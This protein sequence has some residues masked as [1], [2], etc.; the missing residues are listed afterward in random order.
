[1]VIAAAAA[2]EVTVG[3]EVFHAFTTNLDAI[4]DADRIPPRSPRATMSRRESRASLIGVR[5]NDALSEFENFKKKFLLANKHITKLNSTLSTK[6]EELNAQISTLYVENLR[7]RASEIALKSQLKRERAKSQ[8]IMAEADSAIANFTKHFG[9]LHE[10]YNVPRGAPS[11]PQRDPP[12]PRARR[13][14]PDPNASPPVP[15]LARAPT[16]PGIYEEDEEGSH[17][18]EPPSP[19]PARRRTKPRTSISTSSSSSRL[20]LPTRVSSPPPVDLE[21]QLARR[22]KP[23]RRQSGLLAKVSSDSSS[24]SGVERPPSPAYGSPARLEAGRAER[25]NEVVATGALVD[26]D[27]DIDEVVVLPRRKDRDR[28]SDQDRDKKATKSS[29]SGESGK[30]RKRHRDGDEG[31]DRS[32]EQSK[33]NHKFQDVTNSPRSRSR[34]RAAPGALAAA[35]KELGSDR[36]RTPDQDADALFGTRTFLT[37]PVTTPPAPDAYP[38]SESSSPPEPSSLDPNM[39]TDDNRGRRARKSV[40]YAEPKLNTKMRKPAGADPAPTVTKR[41]RMSTS[42]SAPNSRGSDTSAP[43]QP[44]QSEI[45]LADGDDTARRGEDSPAVVRRSRKMRPGE[46]DRADE[47]E[48]ESEGTQADA[49]IGFGT[50][51]DWSEAVPNS[52]SLGRRRSAQIAQARIGI[53]TMEA[54][55]ERRHSLAI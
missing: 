29:R 14:V 36:Q 44:G 3:A 40:N 32:S 8:K 50:R 52:T 13:P 2:G 41:K 31:Y 38:T 27:E 20:P 16:I 39:E 37:T 9:F 17:S 42:S 18:E 12:P 10:S 15:R 21:E 30:E 55:E 33:S 23:T 7:L 35:A 43:A 28:G 4:D 5:Q 22:R 47:Q 51:R 6:I 11:S 49:E 53:I 45:P 46:M 24:L 1:M 26:A 48:D 19:T 54:A 25:A 34:D